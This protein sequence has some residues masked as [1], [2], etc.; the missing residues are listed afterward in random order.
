[1][2]HVLASAMLV[3]A[4]STLAGCGR[5]DEYNPDVENA[6]IRAEMGLDSPKLEPTNEGFAIAAPSDPGAS[7]R[8]LKIK[9]RGNGNLEVLSR[10]DGPSGTSFARREIDCQ[11]Y[12]YRYLGEGDTRAEAEVNSSNPGKMAELT[13]TSASSD[14]ANAACRKGAK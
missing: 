7:F 3:L 5:A 9:R 13:G 1:M 6:K 14:V 12:T 10:R 4:V 2:Q 11:A 8:I